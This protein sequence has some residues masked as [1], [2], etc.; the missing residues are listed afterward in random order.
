MTQKA[1][2]DGFT[3]RDRSE[4]GTLNEADE[5]VTLAVEEQDSFACQ[6]TTGLTG[7]L[8]AEV[9]VDGGTT[10]AAT[11][12]A[13]KT[14]GTT[15]SS[16]VNPGTG[17]Y[18]IL[19]TAG[20]TH[21]RVRCSAYTSGSAEVVLRGTETPAAAGA[22]LANTA[23]LDANTDQL[24]GY[25]D[26]LETLVTSTNT[27][28]DTLNAAIKAEDSA[29]ADGDSGLVTFGRRNDSNAS[30]TGSDGD[31]GVFSQDAAGNSIVVGPAADNAA[32]AGSPVRI[33]GKY[34]AA[35]QSYASGDV[36]DLQT[37]ANGFLKI[38]GTTI[39]AQSMAGN[40]VTIGLYTADTLPSGAGAD[41]RN[42]YAMGT[43]KGQ[44]RTINDSDYGHPSNATSGTITMTATG[45]T[46]VIAAAGASTRNVARHYQIANTSATGVRV[47]ILDG[48]TV[49][50][51]VWVA[52]TSTVVGNCYVRSTANTALRADCSASVTDLRISL[53]GYTSIQ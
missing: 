45:A 38:S 27:K 17:A 33:A 4:T 21:V 2:S 48:A 51:S 53:Q 30:R 25:L 9:S 5:A 39:A 50:F 46:D 40:P 52:G 15:S 36:A 3:Y 16:L 14:T 20:C 34:N 42:Y 37:D 7:T 11:E 13:S 23:D 6:I 32:A 44:L 8:V 22:G 35:N 19:R 41:G 49:K 43:Q 24:E 29:G 10:Y 12:F 26:G 28:L 47:D 1:S 18:D 31:Y